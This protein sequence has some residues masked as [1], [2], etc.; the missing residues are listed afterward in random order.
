[1]TNDVIDTRQ[2]VA[3]AAAM[4]VVSGVAL[5]WLSADVARVLAALVL[6]LVYGIYVGMALV[7]ANPRTLAVENAF[8]CVGVALAYLGLRYG[9]GW[10]FA[11]Y[12]LH[13]VWD[14]LHHPDRRTL[15]TDN[16]P[17]WYVPACV[18][19]DWIVAV[20]VLAFL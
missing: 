4:A 17:R 12:V 18:A 6:V 8:A 9:T 15:G 2:G 20:A 13:G 10:L 14:L 16:V 1:M 19:Y 5:A 11:G 3:A 7:T